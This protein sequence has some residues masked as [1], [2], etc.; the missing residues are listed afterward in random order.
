MKRI[1]IISDT[2]GRLSR[3][4]LAE[5]KGADLVIHAGDLTSEADWDMLQNYVPIKAVLGNNDS[6]YN[7]DP[8]LKR[9]NTFE[10]EGL[11][12]AV[13]HYREDLPV[14][15][16]DVGICG[17]T[18]R[19]RVAEQGRCLVVNP[20][21]ATSPRDSAKPSIARMYVEDGKVVSVDIL[22]IASAWE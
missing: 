20:G 12:F 19:A 22:R 8:P 11:V 2:H 6:F 14:G 16:I 9:L 7:Y 1:D 3:A 10:Y 5:I 13:S 15:A 4:L 18:H 21:S 17:H